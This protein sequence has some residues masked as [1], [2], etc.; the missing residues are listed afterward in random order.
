[1][2]V[3][4]PCCKEFLNKNLDKG[5]MKQ[6]K[7]LLVSLW[8]LAS[9][10][11]LFAQEEPANLVVPP[12]PT[13]TTVVQEEPVNQKQK[14]SMLDQLQQ[15][16]AEDKGTT[17]VLEEAEKEEPTALTPLEKEIAAE[18]FA[19]PQQE[20][21]IIE[22]KK[23]EE[24]KE[25]KEEK[26][27]QEKVVQEKKEEAKNPIYLGKFLNPWEF[28]NINELIEIDLENAE[29]SNFISYIE[30][31]FNL[32]FII[33]DQLN[34]PPAGGKKVLGTKISFRSH[35]PLS[36][37]EAWDIFVS[38]LDLAGLAPQP[39]PQPGVYRITSNDLKSPFSINKGPLPTFINIDMSL[40]PDNDMRIRYV[41]FV[42]NSSIDVIK[43]IV[44][45][46]RSATSPNVIV[47]PELRAIIMTDRATNIKAMLEI[48]RELD[49]VNMPETLAVIKL[50][51][52]DATKVANLYKELVKDEAQNNL[53]ARLLGPR[54]QP[55]TSYFPEG[56][57]VIAEPRT[58][59]LILLGDKIAI[60]RIENFIKKHIDKE[61]DIP[62]SPLHVYQLK[63]TEAQAVAEILKSAIQFQAESDAA[64]YGGVRDGDKFFKPIFIT[65][66]KSGNRLIINADYDD[67]VK[68][69]ELLQKIDVE[70]PQ[71]AIKALILSINLADT[72]DLGIQM[73]NKVPGPNGLIGNNVN[74]QTTGLAGIPANTS[75]GLAQNAVV[76]NTTGTGATRLLGN[77]VN[78]ATNAV[79]GSTLIT[80]GSDQ[81]GIWGILNIL[82]SY[83]CTNIIANPFLVATHKTPALVA[84]GTTR[85]ILTGQTFTN[86]GP[87]QSLDDMT[88][89]LELYVEPQISYEGYITMGVRVLLEQFTSTDQTS[90]NRTQQ[91][92][93]TTVIM[94]NNEVL[95]LGGLTQ[96]TIN[97][98]ESKV[99]ILGDIPIFG[100][101]FKNK[102]RVVQKTSLIIL[103]T[104]EIIPAQSNEAANR[105]TD[106]KLSYAKS[107][108]L[109]T[110]TPSTSR[111]PF[112]RWFFQSNTDP[113]LKIINTYSQEGDRY[114]A[115]SQK[116]EYKKH[117]GKEPSPV[118]PLVSLEQ[119][120]KELTKKP[121]KKRKRL[122]ELIEPPAVG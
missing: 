66:E 40:I 83:T 86:S 31:R 103:L 58:N 120:N 5:H 44:D 99:P 1:M 35:R 10:F 56:T 3:A 102:S 78:L 25:E 16:E 98:S 62:F 108:N 105:F 41:Y 39:G 42:E 121:A 113:E 36:K 101:L 51:R 68:I 85:R 87:V 109:S 7:V 73:R 100:W 69:F 60:Q 8:I 122:T 76:E 26:I 112:N 54:K 23:I 74:Y 20:Q 118:V 65:A 84:V 59:T 71:V 97:E 27:A 64:K 91:E 111:D 80:L 82:Q 45:N 114:L 117:T 90:G 93:K 49:T 22:A 72:R 17:E 46:M 43:N 115:E 6:M 19:T 50:K 18:E 24:K 70:Q 33:D 77:L 107:L 119:E 55:T 104:P 11:F 15:D 2:V 94:A 75:T 89:K 38:F 13:P 9:S 106:S 32:T 52:T 95:A 12:A 96:D 116:P 57:R 28:G 67:Y 110:N 79:Q 61:I 37:K 34:P 92:V 29:L 47:Y 48:I 81:F 53:A 63:Y 88:A 21:K 4:K 14:Q 30:K